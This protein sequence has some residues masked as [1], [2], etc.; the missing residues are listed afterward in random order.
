MREKR[1]VIIIS[2]QSYQSYQMLVPDD[3][4][5][6][7]DGMTLSVP[8]G[9]AWSHRSC[10]TMPHGVS[11][12]LCH[13]CWVMMASHHTVPRTEEAASLIIS[14]EICPS[15]LFIAGHGSLP[16]STPGSDH[17]TSTGPIVLSLSYEDVT[18]GVM[19][20]SQQ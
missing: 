3:I 6:S 18:Q 12:V 19:D 11:T 8:G 13:L 2:Y 5:T 17:L 14:P 16:R 20:Y 9:Q 4:V 15:P 10:V 1:R 7:P